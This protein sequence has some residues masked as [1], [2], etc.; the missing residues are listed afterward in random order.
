MLYCKLEDKTATVTWTWK[1][2]PTKKYISDVVP[3][4][5]TVETVST[6]STSLLGTWSMI[7]YDTITA[8]S[9][10]SYR[11]DTQDSPVFSNRRILSAKDGR[12]LY[13]DGST[14]AGP[15]QVRDIK[16]TPDTASGYKITISNSN[17]SKLLEDKK[18]TDSPPTYE[19]A[20]G[21][22]CPEGYI[23]CETTTYPGY[24]CLPCKATAEKINN[25][26]SKI[27]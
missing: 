11:G 18:T 17:G 8:N 26:A 15:I 2:E 23:K 12:E 3:V 5:V 16:F 20:C 4:G 7:T 19:V 10:F 6:G 25:L 14:Y 24:C 27:R 1:N 13:S 22:N 9:P 21:E